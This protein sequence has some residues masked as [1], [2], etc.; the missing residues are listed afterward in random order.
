M[1]NV[2]PVDFLPWGFPAKEAVFDFFAGAGSEARRFWGV[3]P[4][5][6]LL[7][8]GTSSYASL[9]WSSSSSSPCSCSPPC[10]CIETWDKKKRRLT[11]LRLAIY[12]CGFRGAIFSTTDGWVFTAFTPKTVHIS[13]TR[14]S[15]TRIK[16]Y[17]S[18]ARLS[19]NINTILRKKLVRR[20]TVKKM[21]KK[22][23]VR[24]KR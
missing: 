20:K 16:M 17:P 15:Q 6:R 24:E 13:P 21:A 22:N 5:F 1:K 23:T 3:L 12:K 4:V 10:S 8:D 18:A 19:I 9:S 14:V 11:L 2:S 7:D